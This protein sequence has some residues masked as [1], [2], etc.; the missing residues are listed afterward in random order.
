MLFTNKNL[1]TDTWQLQT[2]SLATMYHVLATPYGHETT[3]SHRTSESSI[4]RTAHKTPFKG[5]AQWCAG[6][7]RETSSQVKSS[8]E[9]EALGF[10]SEG[11]FIWATEE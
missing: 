8:P 10:R 4:S 5:Y 3:H 7:T 9:G 1:S 6:S 11:A 2:D